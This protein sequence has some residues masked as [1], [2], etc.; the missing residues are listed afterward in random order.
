MENFESKINSQLNLGKEG[1]QEV[2][3]SQKEFAEYFGI[4]AANTKMMQ[5]MYAVVVDGKG[6]GTIHTSM[7][8]AIREFL[9]AK[10]VESFDELEA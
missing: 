10:G 4:S 8:K 5:K 9:D 1:V 6:T 7:S 3:V 2:F